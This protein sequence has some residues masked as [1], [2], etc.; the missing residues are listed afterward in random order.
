[1]LSKWWPCLMKIICSWIDISVC[2]YLFLGKTFSK[3]KYVKSYY[4]S[5]LPWTYQ[6]IL[7]RN[8]FWTQI[9]WNNYENYSWL[10]YFEFYQE[11]KLWNSSLSCYVNTYIVVVVVVYLL[12]HVWLFCNPIDCC[13]SDS[14]GHGILQ[15]RILEWVVMPSSRASSWLRDWTPVSASPALQADSLATGEALNRSPKHLHNILDFA[16]WSFTG[17]VCQLLSI[18]ISSLHTQRI[19]GH[20]LSG[21]NFF[22]HPCSLSR[23]QQRLPFQN[24]HL[25]NPLP[26][27]PWK[28]HSCGTE[29]LA[30]GLISIRIVWCGKST[31]LVSEVL[32]VS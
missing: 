12:S 31:H 21:S 20:E 13:S 19:L 16:S 2:Q 22:I 7:I 28:F 26:G 32:W 4:R 29:P 23:T 17:K 6:Q 8:T 5:A 30:C 27:K 25:L 9:K 14:S 1:M 15:A 24:F 18:V 10:L 11:K 3:M